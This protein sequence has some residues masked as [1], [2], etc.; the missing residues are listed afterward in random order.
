MK[1]TLEMEG[2]GIVGEI[3]IH[4]L[5]QRRLMRA[6]WTNLKGGHTRDRVRGKLRLERYKG[7]VPERTVISE[8]AVDEN[9]G[10]SK[11]SSKIQDLIL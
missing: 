5:P 9:I 8:E 10:S 11:K 3:T 7:F 4:P 2:F 1:R 6:H